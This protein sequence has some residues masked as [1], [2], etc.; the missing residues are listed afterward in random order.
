M[1]PTVGTGIGFLLFPALRKYFDPLVDGVTS[2]FEPIFPENSPQGIRQILGDI[3]SGLFASL[4]SSASPLVEVMDPHF[5]QC[6]FHD[7]DPRLIESAFSS[8]LKNFRLLTTDELPEVSHLVSGAR[9]IA[10]VNEVLR[11]YHAVIRTH[12]ERQVAEL[13]LLNTL[14]QISDTPQE[15]T[16]AYLGM[17]TKTLGADYGLIYYEKGQ[18][19]IR[20]ERT[21][22]H[23]LKLSQST[24][25]LLLKDA[26]THDP[27]LVDQ[28]TKL[29]RDNTHEDSLSPFD[30]SAI[31][32]E[33]LE[34]LEEGLFLSPKSPQSLVNRLHPR[35]LLLS[36]LYSGDERVGF[37]ALMREHDPP[38][39]P[40]DATFLGVS[41]KEMARILENRHLQR[42][43][44]RLAQTDGLTGLLNRRQFFE[45]ATNELERSRRYGREFGLLMIDVDDFKEINDTWG[46]QVGDR[47]LKSLADFLG[48]RART[49]DLVARYGGEEFILLLLEASA[50]SARR[51][52]E[53]LNEGVA[54]LKIPLDGKD[55]TMTISV[56]VSAFPD[57]GADLSQVISAADQ[58][59]Y[60]AKGT[61][62]DCVVL[63]Q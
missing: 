30:W 6:V 43:L 60:L 4:P 7:I 3:V 38:F 34:D 46:H 12:Y 10:L 15:L 57:H 16:E 59:L 13:S 39:S 19:S 22:S 28:L 42:E 53:G 9:S 1:L 24:L 54:T 48:S 61:G 31:E 44:R 37:V 51:M 20:K 18:E 29:F 2:S 11:G 14:S 62:K 56:G 35:S 36:P 5:H 26:E 52:A 17:V 45:V 47:V 21:P 32:K 50:D 8:L 25:E 27:L 49:G 55:L 58:A 63:S 33:S 41:S 23:F 40:Q